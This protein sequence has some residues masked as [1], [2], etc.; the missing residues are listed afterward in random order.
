MQGPDERKGMTE[1]L[2]LEG[3]YFCLEHTGTLA[4]PA[5][6]KEMLELIEEVS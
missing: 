1:T 2:D 6:V 4:C 3:K 5:L